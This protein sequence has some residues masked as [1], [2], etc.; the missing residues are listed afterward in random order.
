MVVRLKDIRSGEKPEEEKKSGI[1]RLSD[2]RPE[3]P[4]PFVSPRG[5]DIYEFSGRTWQDSMDRIAEIAEAGRRKEVTEKAAKKKEKANLPG[6]DIPVI[7]PILKGLDTFSEAIK[8]ATD[9]AEEFYTPGAGLS[10]LSAGTRAAGAL[11]S[12][13]APSLGNSSKILPRA[14]TRAIEE[15]AVGVPVGAGNVLARDPQASGR[16]IAEG[17]VF[18]GAGGALLG[19]VGPV[20]GAGVRRGLQSIVRPAIDSSLSASKAIDDVARESMPQSVRRV[21]SKDRVPEMFPDRVRR[22][23][24]TEPVD[25]GVQR[26]V[27]LKDIRQPADEPIG[28]GQR[29]NFGTQVNEGNFSDEL[30]QRI[31]STDQS[32]EIQTNQA[33]L[34]LAN[35]KL[36]NITLAES[37]FIANKEFSAEHVATGYRLMQEFDKK[38][39]SATNPALRKD[40]F[41]KAIN[42][43]EKLA[44]DLTK[45]GQTVQAASVLSRL[46]PEGQL[47]ALTRKA[48]SSGKTV[49]V[50]DKIKFQELAAKVQEKSGA[51]IRAN[52]FNEILNRMEKGENVGVDDIKKLSDYLS[53]AEKV[54]KPKARPV[55]DD[56]PD[57]FKD[58]RKRDKIISFLDDAEQA[59]LARIAARKNRLNALPVDEWT[60]HAI[61]VA[62]QIAKG[63]IKA[64]THVEDLVRMF[65][66]EIRPVATHVFQQAQKLVGG[67]S[68]NAAEGNLAK[69]NE[70]FRR[71]TGQ[72]KEMNVQEKV[73]ERYLKEN[74]EVSQKDIDTLRE[75]AKNVTRLSGDS[76]IEAD[77]AMQK[78]LNSYEKS[79]VWDKILAMRYMGMLLNTSTQAINALSGPIMATTGV[80]ADVFGTMLD[81][82]MNKVLKTPRTT[83]LYGTNPLKFIARYVKYLKTGSK[84]GAQGVNPAGIQ[85]T[86]EIRGLAFK[87]MK[88]PL[89]F[90]PAL[91]ERVLG[92]VAKGPDFAT[93]KSVFDSEIAKQGYLSAK[94]SGVK[95][96]VNI[97][98]HVEAFVNNPPEEAILQADRIGKNTTFQRAD[99]T[100][101]KVANYL[102]N[103]PTLVKPG[104]NAVF[105]FVRT[106]INIASTAVTMTPAGII[107]G[108]VQLSSLSDASRRE[109]IRTL[110][111]GV[112]G[113]GIGAIGYYL[114][115]LG[116][117]TGA[118]DSGD[119]DL[120][121]VREQAG[122]GKYRFNQSALLRYLSALFNGEGSEV[123]E[124]AAQYQEGDKQ[125]D[126]NKLQPL[127]FPLAAGA[128]LGNNKDKPLEQKAGSVGADAFGSLF[129]MST[130]KGVQNVFQPSYGGS[131]GEKALG[132]PSR[133][134][135]S[136]FKSFSPGLL[137]Q[138]A[139]RQDPIQRKTP[140]N[141]GLVENT[142]EYFKSRIPG[143][144]ESLPPR[145][146]TLGQDYRN[147]P[148]VAGSYLN[149][150]RSE[151][152]PYN[153]AARIIV[154]LIDR[155]GDTSLAPR[156]PEKT[157]RGKDRTG[158]SVSI[159]IPQDRYTQLQEDIGGQIVE[160]ISALP[161]MDDKRLTT[162]IEKIYTS[163]REKEMNKVKRELGLRVSS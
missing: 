152:A 85:G 52:E 111:M 37:E 2:I 121:N 57:D 118:N 16:E 88:N 102:N 75:L 19:P 5:E 58:V 101:G 48:K 18:G 10:A 6:R 103:S 20:V 12:R 159:K 54:I 53:G 148:G 64:A 97:R 91:G 92:A 22:D 78:I 69:A 96:R 32:Y 162:A 66:D 23:F 86:N 67:V 109:A 7:G 11:V 13:I 107:K 146:T 84:A 50:E 119:K 104:V 136:F 115:Q 56:L 117:I 14:A 4:A 89:T 157:V 28:L 1:V 93:Y 112:T 128:S 71:I 15:A 125:F 36:E 55:V 40:F 81:I 73:V 140:F 80:A 9:I 156:A 63:T 145:K 41:Q 110:S 142:T 74:P 47:L 147:A 100:G 113:T 99:T 158:A 95:G 26:I 135:E 44:E 116:I 60:D 126:Y 124:K 8:P 94:N 61:V 43:A 134:A 76:K 49:T 46:S 139:R 150:Y 106:P 129:G 45:A 35:K 25:E 17:A 90:V 34:D 133:I 87:S 149:P 143:L 151:V 161:K 160:R 132:V 130:L 141:E 144:S 39:L 82:A 42:V 68:R 30:Q 114:S 3:K 138:E 79:N 24:S 62:A 108:L 59:A 131:Q 127:A 33:S 51:G 21:V 137:A 77:I 122:R 38:A 155:T 120:D 29:A 153:E 27:R 31:R 105:P 123:A 163:V 70:S 98:K 72:T 65:G 83:T 154:E